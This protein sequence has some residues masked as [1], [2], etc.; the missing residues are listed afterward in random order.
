MVTVVGVLP[1]A[2]K[3]QMLRFEGAWDAHEK[4]GVQLRAARSEEVAPRSHEALTAY[5]AGSALPGAR[6]TPVSVIRVVAACKA[7]GRKYC[8]G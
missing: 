2:L 4:F 3:G 7:G 8:T 1:H 5:L 6:P